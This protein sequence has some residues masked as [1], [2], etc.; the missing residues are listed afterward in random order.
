[1]RLRSS[2][3]GSQAPSGRASRRSRARCGG[4]SRRARH[5]GAAAPSA[6][7]ADRGKLRPVRDAA[8]A[9]GVPGGAREP[10]GGAAL[11]APQRLR[12]GLRQ[13]LD[14]LWRVP[15]QVWHRAGR[16][17]RG[18]PG[19]PRLRSGQRGA[20]FAPDGKRACAQWEDGAGLP[21][22]KSPPPW[23]SESRRTFVVRDGTLEVHVGRQIRRRRKSIGLSRQELAN[24]IGAT[25]NDIADL[26][27][28]CRRA[29]SAQLIGLATAL[30]APL[31]YFFS[32]AAAE[33]LVGCDA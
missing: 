15:P 1:M 33:A 19:T 2:T 24:A 17:A 27:G 22:K 9:P 16:A 28:G 6:V 10:G 23:T 18:F 11:G 5:F 14:L 25:C 20:D 8:P 31:S 30:A 21:P 13:R 32:A 3:V 12:L 26:E 29:S 4:R 7:R